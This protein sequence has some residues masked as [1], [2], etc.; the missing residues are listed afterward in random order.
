MLSRASS[1]RSDHLTVHC[2]QHFSGTVHI[3]TCVSGAPVRA[4][5]VGDQ[6]LGKTALCPGVDHTIEI[7]ATGTIAQYRLAPAD[8]HIER[9]GDSVATS[10]AALLPQ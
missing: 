8:V 2:P 9:S 1:L 10:I 7:Q 3:N 5:T 4:V 6:G